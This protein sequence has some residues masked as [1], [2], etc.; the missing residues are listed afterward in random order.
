MIFSWRECLL[1]LRLDPL[2]KIL[3]AQFFADELLALSHPEF[4]FDLELGIFLPV[5]KDRPIR[6]LY[7]S[8]LTEP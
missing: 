3:D 6:N 8:S 1:V 7:P 4:E 2:G 5:R